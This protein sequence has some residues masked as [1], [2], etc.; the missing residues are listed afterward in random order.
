M[1]QARDEAISHTVMPRIRTYTDCYRMKEQLKK[2]KILV[3]KT[4]GIEN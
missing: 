2:K 4:D 1:I 3:I